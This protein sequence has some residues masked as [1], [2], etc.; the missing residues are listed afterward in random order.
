[1]MTH[2]T[3]TCAKSAPGFPRRVIT[4]AMA[5]LLGSCLALGILA[6]LAG[7][8]AAHADVPKVGDTFVLATDAKTQWLYDEPSAKDSAGKIVVHWFCTKKIAACQDEL[9]RLVTLRDETRTYIIAYIDGTAADAKKLDPIRESEGIGHG[10]VA[11]GPSVKK[12]LKSLNLSLLPASIVVDV[13][14]TVAMVTTGIAVEELDARDAKVKALSSAIKSYAM[15]Q[16]GPST[17]KPDESFTLS[18]TIQLSKWLSFSHKTPMEFSLSVPKDI[19]CD[20]TTL[21]DDKLKIE[22]N[23]LTAS[24]KCSAPKGIYEARGDIRFGYDT[25]GGG[26][27]LGNDGTKWRFEVKP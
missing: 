25:P 1:M 4:V 2:E 24:V 13:D 26:A 23:T 10:T 17:V 22:G 9:A 3:Q 5:R 6:G 18:L 14:G 7:L 12:L 8:P 21:K 11:Y 16:A 15:T 20:A 27:G 19:K